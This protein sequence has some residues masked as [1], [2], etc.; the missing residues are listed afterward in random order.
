MK[1]FC[2]MVLG[3]LSILVM[4]VMIV[5]QIDLI[6]PFLSLSTELMKLFLYVNTYGA[7]ILIAGWSLVYFWGKGAKVIPTF[8]V[9]VLIALG[10]VVFCFPDSITKIFGA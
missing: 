3:L 4:A 8:V 5:V 10:I 1:K 7:I 9:L 2:Y 6:H